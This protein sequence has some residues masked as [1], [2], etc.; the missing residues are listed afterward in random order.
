MTGV[1]PKQHARTG[2]FYLEEAVLDVLLEF[3]Y[4]DIC[5]GSAEISRKAGIYR[6]RGD[7]DAMNDAI[8]TGILVK[9][10]SEGRVARCTQ[11]N[12]KGGWELTPKEFET[13]REDIQPT[14]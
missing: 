5:V 4:E 11:D 10:H 12:N 9:L 3:K 13:R 8:T 6:D 14:P 2:V 1:R 7:A